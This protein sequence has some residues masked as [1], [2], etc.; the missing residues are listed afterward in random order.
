MSPRKRI[1]ASTHCRA[2][3]PAPFLLPSLGV[4]AGPGLE[5][6]AAGWR[7]ADEAT[8]GVGHSLQLYPS[9]LS[10]APHFPPSSMNLWEG[11]GKPVKLSIWSFP[12]TRVVRERERMLITCEGTQV[13]LC[14]GASSSASRD[15]TP[16]RCSEVEKKG[17]CTQITWGEYYLHRSQSSGCNKGSDEA[18]T[19]EMGSLC[20]TQAR[21]NSSDIAVL[22]GS[23]RRNGANQVTRV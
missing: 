3:L 8:P 12:R 23:V 19:K 6:A 13:V 10:S 11:G 9:V 1:R 20:G 16:V 22:R 21:S 18:C 17:F 2:F 14:A 7:R 4:G 15:L 5:G